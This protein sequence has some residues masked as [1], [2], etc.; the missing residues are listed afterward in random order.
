[1]TTAL[2]R[3][4]HGGWVRLERCSPLL[5]TPPWG[6]VVQGPYLNQV[7]LAR[8]ALPPRPLMR[9]LLAVERLGGRDRS[10]EVRWGPR[11]IDLDLLAYDDLVYRDA[12]VEIPHPRLHERRFVLE[13]LASILPEW[14]HPVLG[15]RVGQ[16][17]DRLAPDGGVQRFYQERRD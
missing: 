10:R 17:L 12:L 16:L 5:Q 2:S 1:M 11:P 8:T 13:P 14:R 15:L 9:W 3:L 7:C 4:Q 6:P